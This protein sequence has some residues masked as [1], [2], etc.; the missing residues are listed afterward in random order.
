MAMIRHS[1]KNRGATYTEFGVTI[2]CVSSDQIGQ[3][4]IL[5]YLENGSANLCFAYQKEI[6]FIPAIMILKGLIDMPDYDIYKNLMRNNEKN[7]F[8]EG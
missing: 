8:M 3:N 2:H 4:H 1:W 7:S 6:F 5:H